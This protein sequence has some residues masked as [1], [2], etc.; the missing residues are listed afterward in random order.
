[1][2]D[3]ELRPVGRYEWEQILRRARLDGVVAGSGRIGASGRAT[4]GSMSGSLFKAIALTWAS[5]AN[6]RGQE[7]WPGDATVAVAAETTLKNAT[8]VRKALLDLGLLQRVRGRQGM[9]GTEH[10]LTIP[11]DLM[12][13]LEVLTP[14]QHTLAA[15]RLRN[16]ARGKPGGSGGPP[17][18]PSGPTS[19]GGPVD[20]PQLFDPSTVG[21]PVD[22]PEPVDNPDLG[23][24]VDPRLGGPV[25]PHTDHGPHQ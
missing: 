12:D 23:G 19:S 25:D 24:P 17:R 10:R 5:Y 18:N 8:A 20:P 3:R 4:R 6:D 15:G 2:P 7:I 14:A 13:R 11:S 16:A 9:R 1:M 22:P 21:A